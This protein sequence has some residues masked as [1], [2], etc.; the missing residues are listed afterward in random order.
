MTEFQE[1]LMCVAL[2]G[3]PILDLPPDLRAEFKGLMV[4]RQHFFAGQEASFKAIGERL[5]IRDVCQSLPSLSSE[6]LPPGATG[7]GPQPV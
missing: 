6:V 7:D 2:F 3:R 1:E 4:D 5:A